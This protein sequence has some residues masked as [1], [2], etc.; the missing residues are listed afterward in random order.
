MYQP[1][2][3]YCLCM[4]YLPVSENKPCKTGVFL[5]STRRDCFKLAAGAVIGSPLAS[6]PVI[7]QTGNEQPQEPSLSGVGFTTR[8]GQ[9]QINFVIVNPT[10]ETIDRTVYTRI[11]D[12]HQQVSEL[13]NQ[14]PEE[15]LSLTVNGVPPTESG[16]PFIFSIPD[17]YTISGLSENVEA[18][19]VLPN[20]SATESDYSWFGPDSDAL[21]PE[22]EQD[23]DSGGVL[24]SV[25]LSPSALIVAGGGVVGAGM[26][27]WRRL[28]QSGEDTDIVAT[29]TDPA[30]NTTSNS[31]T[32][33]AT[34]DSDTR[35]ERATELVTQA[36]EAEASGQYQ[37]AADAYKEAVSNFEQATA[38]GN[39]ETTEELKAEIEETQ[40]SFESVSA[41][42]E[43]RESVTMTIQA[44]E[45]SFKEAIARYRAGNR[46]V[47][48]IRFRQARD[49]FAEAQQAIA[50]DDTEVLAHPIEIS[51]EEEATLPSMA[52]EN[53]TVLE[54]S[55]VETLSTVDIKSVD[56]LE[57]DTS[58]LTPPVVTDLQQS[59]EIND[60]E[61]PLLTILSWWYE[62]NSREFA[63]EESISRRYDQADYG[64]DHST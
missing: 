48:R 29:T 18:A 54:E 57:A 6:N 20:D 4:I 15:E 10:E 30:P 46:T 51:F 9:A 45:R 26:Y 13:N 39:D 50:D 17:D 32:E 19:L 43:A 62:G 3:V 35:Q 36:T 33:E 34:G 60:E 42:I 24:P 21:N 28:R 58:E 14:T 23:F 40:A 11:Y 1:Q 64:F 12:A 25:G 27:A 2:M 41:V 63:S 7:A 44:A 8:G 16:S 47:A 5:T 56:D 52:L 61:A 59:D 31:S 49:A 37:Q 22:S 55:T 38:G 53:L